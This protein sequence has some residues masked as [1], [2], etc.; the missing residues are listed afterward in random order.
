MI[1]RFLIREK[2]LI[3]E[4]RRNNSRNAKTILRDITNLYKKVR[5]II[6]RRAKKENYYD[7][8][9]EIKKIP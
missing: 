2:L 4:I 8:K 7:P 3:L 6:S 1:K 5:R 9:N